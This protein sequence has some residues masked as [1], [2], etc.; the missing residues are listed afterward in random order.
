MPAG[1][2]C[3]RVETEAGPGVQPSGFQPAGGVLQNCAAPTTATAEMMPMTM[4]VEGM[5]DAKR[6][7]SAPMSRSMKIP[8]T[9]GLTPIPITARPTIMPRLSGNHF[10]SVAMGATYP[11]PVPNPTTQP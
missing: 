5:V 3:W 10:T 8:N 7:A 1:G 6:L 4:N 9:S 11:N 2:T